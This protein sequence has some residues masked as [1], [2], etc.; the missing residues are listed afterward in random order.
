MGSQA[1]FAALGASGHIDGVID[2]VVGERERGGSDAVTTL[3]CGDRLLGDALAGDVSGDPLGFRI[4]SG[5]SKGLVARN[6]GFNGAIVGDNGLRFTK[7]IS[8]FGRTRRAKSI[9]CPAVAFGSGG[10]V[11]VAELL[12]M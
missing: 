4:P 2:T 5:Q 6:A 10:E 3:G 1:C 8:V 12:G 11:V 7:L 9:R